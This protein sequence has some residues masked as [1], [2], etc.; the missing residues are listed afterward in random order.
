[1]FSTG[2]CRPLRFHDGRNTSREARTDSFLKAVR[3][4]LSMRTLVLDTEISGVW[5]LDLTL[6]LN[7]EEQARAAR[8]SL[9]EGRKEFQRYWKK[10]CT[11]FNDTVRDPM[12]R[13]NLVEA[14]RRE[15]SASAFGLR[16]PE[17]LLKI[18]SW[19]TEMLDKE[20]T[21]NSKGTRVGAG[22]R[23]RSENYLGLIGLF[24]V[25]L[26]DLLEN[27]QQVRL[28]ATRVQSQNNLK[29]IALAMIN[30]ADL[31]S[32]SLPSARSTAKTVSRC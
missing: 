30:Y 20:L 4:L 16:E 29:Q 2:W 1:M 18:F 26:S 9:E 28:E 7:N 24:A 8:K 6:T 22:F 27:V 5:K 25:L 23:T 12:K 11:V 10:V 17:Q 19:F 14:M 13:K 32:S 21:I 31:N 15:P 3:P